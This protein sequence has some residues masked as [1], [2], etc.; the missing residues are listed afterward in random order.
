MQPIDTGQPRHAA[1]A[2]PATSPAQMVLMDPTASLKSRSA[3]TSVEA[4]GTT[5]T[6]RA[7]PPAQAVRQV[8]QVTNNSDPAANAG[9]TPSTASGL[10]GRGAQ[11]SQPVE[12][13]D[14][15]EGGEPTMRIKPLFGRDHDHD[16]DHHHHKH[17][18]RSRSRRRH[19]SRRHS[20]C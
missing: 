6:H 8:L 5:T 16:H 3:K 2:R 15:S 19:H 12:I 9:S 20:R 11:I 13:S 18:H 4:I 1:T 10:G 14:T 17:R 7:V